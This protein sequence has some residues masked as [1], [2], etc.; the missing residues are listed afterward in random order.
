MPQRN[1]NAFA[2]DQNTLSGWYARCSEARIQCAAKAIKRKAP[3]I[4]ES[5]NE[6]QVGA[7][8]RNRKFRI[9]IAN[10][11]FESRTFRSTRKRVMPERT[12]VTRQNLYQSQWWLRL[13]S[14]TAENLNA[15]QSEAE[16]S[17]VS[18]RRP[19]VRKRGSRLQLSRP[20]ILRLGALR[21]RKVR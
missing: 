16:K 21:K 14:F 7:L 1:L 3:A 5:V 17:E 15:Q 10:F 2:E 20:L 9:S 4:P 13:S 12:S 11:G 6:K 18:G 19:G 8:S